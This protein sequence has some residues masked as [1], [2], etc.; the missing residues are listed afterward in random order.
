M[1]RFIYKEPV[2]DNQDAVHYQME[3]KC[4]VSP[5]TVI[6]DVEWDIRRDASMP[7]WYGT[8]PRNRVVKMGETDWQLN[9]QGEDG[10]DLDVTQNPGL[11]ELFS[12]DGPGS[13]ILSYIDGFGYSMKGKFRE[14][15]EVKVGNRWYICSPYKNW[16]CVVHLL[17]QDEE[18][19]YVQDQSHDNEGVPGT[20][21]GFAGSW[22]EY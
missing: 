10:K 15:V 1:G 21:G 6:E 13:L 7:A 16:R 9:G 3:L 2:N 4:Q 17:Y 18:H 12:I 20:I 8:A 19:G 14:W 22:G 11:E 5:D